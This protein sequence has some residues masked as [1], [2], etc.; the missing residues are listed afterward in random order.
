M[1]KMKVSPSFILHQ[2][3][4][5]SPSK[6]DYHQ[7]IQI[8]SIWDE[9][10]FAEIKCDCKAPQKYWNKN[11]FIRLLSKFMWGGERIECAKS[12]NKPTLVNLHGLI[13]I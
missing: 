4:A 12:R 5:G 7:T 13:T 3:K 9:K 6:L 10:G 2:D 11:Q 8:F 1:H